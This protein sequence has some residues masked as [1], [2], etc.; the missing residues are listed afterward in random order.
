MS[1]LRCFIIFVCFC[2]QF[3]HACNVQ[4]KPI[5]TPDAGAFWRVISE[6]KVNNVFA[7]PTAW[8]AIRKEDP[9]RSFRVIAV[10]EFSR[11]PITWS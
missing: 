8:R 9:E 2:I 3:V 6:H 4:G 7:A 5:K 10:F 11:F 1:N